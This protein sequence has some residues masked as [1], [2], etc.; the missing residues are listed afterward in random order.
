MSEELEYHY[1][2]KEQKKI[3]NSK[4]SLIYADFTKDLHSV[5]D[6]K[7]EIIEDI[8]SDL[9]PQL[10][11]SQYSGITSWG[12]E[13]EIKNINNRQEEL[14]P[15]VQET[16]ER[17]EHEKMLM[18]LGMTQE[19]FDTHEKQAEEGRK[20]SRLARHRRNK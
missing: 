7:L 8:L 6:R 17:I 16:I 13:D 19:Q 1:W 10:D 4:W 14:E 5:Y 3:K 18:D 11:D 20:K 2:E 12:Y 9:S 15:I